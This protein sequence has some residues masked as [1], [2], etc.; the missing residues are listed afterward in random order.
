MQ[1]KCEFTYNGTMNSSMSWKEVEDVPEAVLKDNTKSLAYSVV[2]IAPEVPSF[3]CIT[4]FSVET[5]DS[6]GLATNIAVATCETPPIKFL[7]KYM[8]DV[9][10]HSAIVLLFM[11]SFIESQMNHVNKRQYRFTECK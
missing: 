5:K 2:A 3:K 11:S 6:Y 4:S 9:Y 10:T 7:C 1:L 8:H